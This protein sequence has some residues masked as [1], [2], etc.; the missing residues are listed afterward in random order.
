MLKRAVLGF[1]D[2]LSISPDVLVVIFMSLVFG[3]DVVVS[4]MVVDYFFGIL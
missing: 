2:I 4:Y 1:V 3:A